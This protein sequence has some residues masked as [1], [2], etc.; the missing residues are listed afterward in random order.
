MLP[1][2][3]P[4]HLSQPVTPS[5]PFAEAVEQ[6]LLDFDRDDPSLP[7]RDPAVARDHRH[8]LRWLRSAALQAL[9]ENPFPKG[10][11]SF[12]EA[13]SILELLDSDR[14]LVPARLEHLTLREPG[15]ALALWRWARRGDKAEPWPTAT[16]HQW[17]DKLIAE[18]VPALVR[19]YALRHALCFALAE[20]DEVRFA[21]LKSS[22]NEDG[23]N[24]F[25]SFQ[26][27]FSMVGGAAPKLRL[28]QLPGLQYQD[29]SLSALA[30]WE[31]G[32]SRRIWICPDEGTFPALPSGTAWVAPSTT[33]YQNSAETD[34]GPNEKPTATAL[35]MRVAMAQ[36]HAYLAPSRADLEA[37][38]F[39]LFPIL[40][41]LQ[42]EGTVSK[43]LMGD[44]APARP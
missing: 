22:W 2:L 42:P 10:S 25:T 21:A 40:V 39:V 17:E 5:I 32:L 9:P 14:N 36:R 37:L 20:Q 15:S 35:S 18:G 28:W 23:T 4:P 41:E 16:R 19:G 30:G 1:F 13:R 29:L 3:V 31:G 12:Q 11:P 34:L 24:M 26:G 33:G 6:V 27:L 7:L 44:A 43:V 8:S 38:G